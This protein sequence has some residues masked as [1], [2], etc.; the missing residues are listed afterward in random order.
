MAKDID[1][2]TKEM[3]DKHNATHAEFKSWCKHCQKGLAMRDR[4]KRK[5][6]KDKYKRRR[7]GEID[8]PDTEEPE[9]GHT[10]FSIDYMR[11]D[12]DDQDKSNASC[13]QKEEAGSDRG[14]GVG[15]RLPAL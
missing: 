5:K 4:H 11:M 2:P 13:M 10:K 9:D 1:T 12:S 3:I 7:L 15:R 6:T 14:T 8:V